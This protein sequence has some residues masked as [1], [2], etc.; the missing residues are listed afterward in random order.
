MKIVYFSF[1]GKTFYMIVC[2]YKYRE[3][4]KYSHLLKEI[5]FPLFLLEGIGF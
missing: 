4:F 5:I 3:R 1:F 2:K